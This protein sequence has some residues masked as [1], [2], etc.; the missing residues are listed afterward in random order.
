MKKTIILF[1]ALALVSSLSFAASLTSMSKEEVKQVLVDHTATS[2]PIDNLDGKDIVN[3]FSMYVAENGKVFGKMSKKPKNDPQTDEGIY[4]IKDD[5]TVYVTWK[6]WDGAKQ[7]C[8][9]IYS[10]QN[11]Y[12]TIDCSHV[13][14]TVFMKSAVIAGNHL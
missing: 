10:T 3:T 12:M 14:H 1:C 11:A 6:N 8:F 7:L 9:N 13:L 4:T 2:I 5:G